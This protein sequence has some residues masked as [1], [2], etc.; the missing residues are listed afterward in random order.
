MFKGV[1]PKNIF[2]YRS[3]FFMEQVGVQDVVIDA[4]CGTGLILGKIASRIKA[5]YGIDYDPKLPQYWNAFPHGDNVEPV[6]ADLTLFDFAAF[7]R[8]TGFNVCILSHVLE[9]IEKP[10]AFLERIN[11]PRLLICVPS[12]EN[13]RAQLLIH[14]GLP[15]FSDPTHFREY[16]RTILRDEL[17]R[18]GYKV[19]TMG[20]NA[21][22]EIVCHAQKIA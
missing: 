9:H 2:N 20:F 5:G 6:L 14:L 17:E 12:Q 11:A 15:Y 10:V 1:H 8:K 4:G 16:T 22:G 21:E 13:W 18:A 7:R 3:E 19:V